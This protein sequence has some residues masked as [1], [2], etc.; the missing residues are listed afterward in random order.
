MPVLKK[1]PRAMSRL[2]AGPKGSTDYRMFGDVGLSF[3]QFQVREDS[4]LARFLHLLKV[5]K[6]ADANERIVDR[7]L[8]NSASIFKLARRVVVDVGRIDTILFG[9]M[10]LAVGSRGGSDRCCRRGFYV[11]SSLNDRACHR[12]GATFV[13]IA[14]RRRTS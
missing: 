6:Q 7:Y 8:A 2:R 1:T 12:S 3:A 13:A 14:V 11:G 9:D 5:L 4:S 10:A